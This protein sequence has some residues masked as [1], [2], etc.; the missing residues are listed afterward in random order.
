MVRLRRS[1]SAPT[2]KKIVARGEQ[3]KRKKRDRL[4][5]VNLDAVRST[6]IRTASPSRKRSLA[7]DKTG[8]K[9]APV[10]QIE[11]EI[12]ICVIDHHDKS[13]GGRR[14]KKPTGG[15]RIG[16]LGNKFREMSHLRT[17]AS[18]GKKRRGREDPTEARTPKNLPRKK[19]KIDPGEQKGALPLYT[20]LLEESFFFRKGVPS[21]LPKVGR[22]EGFREGS[23]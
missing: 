15:Q 10:L 3:K 7:R 23:P 11:G 20:G 22:S 9:E 17:D 16:L 1:S 5:E 19:R 4:E 2:G 8:G 6:T 12:W 13:V 18:A 14:E 21:V